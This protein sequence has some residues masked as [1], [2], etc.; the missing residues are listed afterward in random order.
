MLPC[1][2]TSSRLLHLPSLSHQYLV[3]KLIIC[4]SPQLAKGHS[5]PI[6]SLVTQVSVSNFEDV[7]PFEVTPL[8]SKRASRRRHSD[9]L[10]ALMARMP[11]VKLLRRVPVVLHTQKVIRPIAAARNVKRRR[12]WNMI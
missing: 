8:H 2:W 12:R 9:E 5:Q 11:Q 3:E 7:H 6:D 4:G 10:K 1:F